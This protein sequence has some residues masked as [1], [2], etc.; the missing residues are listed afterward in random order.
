MDLLH[1][2][3]EPV[4]RKRLQVGAESCVNCEHMQALVTNMLQRHWEWHEDKRTDLQPGLYRYSAAFMTRFGREDGFR[5][6]PAFCGMK[7][8]HPDKSPRTP[9][10]R[11]ALRSARCSRL[12]K[13]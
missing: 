12:R 1:E 6:G 3:K 7:D 9:D 10:S 13:F 5:C 11:F 4:E 8:S 2:E